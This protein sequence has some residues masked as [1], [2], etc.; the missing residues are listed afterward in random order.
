MQLENTK[1]I[2][3]RL[4]TRNSESLK[5]ALKDIKPVYSQNDVRSGYGYI[6]HGIDEVDQNFIYSSLD[7]LEYYI[8]ETTSPFTFNL[9]YFV[10][11]E[12]IV[13]GL[14]SAF[15]DLEINFIHLKKLKDK[16]K[17]IESTKYPLTV[18]LNYYMGILEVLNQVKNSKEFIEFKDGGI[19][20]KLKS[21]NENLKFEK[22][23]SKRKWKYLSH[24]LL[25][26]PFLIIASWV[27]I[28][29]DSKNYL[30][31]TKTSVVLTA[32]LI[33][34]LFNLL[35]NNHSSFKE[36][37]KLFT[38]KSREKLIKQEREKFTQ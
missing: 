33:T 30:G 3:D 7:S 24:L 5:R 15:E 22:Y 21:E 37:W 4:I 20:E 2:L 17:D 14:D 26:I 25:F 31:Y 23:W 32:G 16:Y 13:K 29:K 19:I 28:S 8:N 1:A 36:S 9:D 38:K 34:I 6:Y 35:F 18:V 11:I 12:N 10:T 27:I